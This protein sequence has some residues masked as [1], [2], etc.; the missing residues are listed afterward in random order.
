MSTFVNGRGITETVGLVW[1]PEIVNQSLWGF[2][3]TYFNL[4][5]DEQRVHY[6]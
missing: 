5:L 6:L 4:P 1:D 2:V 3:V